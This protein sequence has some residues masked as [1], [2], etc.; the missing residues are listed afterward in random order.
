MPSLAES[1]LRRSQRTPRSM[2]APLFLINLDDATERRE[3]MLAQLH[4]RG[5]VARR[6]GIDCRNLTRRQLAA[7]VARR[8][9]TISFDFESLSGAEI[10]CWMSH[11]AAWAAFLSG[12]SGD[13]CAVIE[14]DV[15]LGPDFV[16]TIAALATQPRFDVVYLGTSSRNVSA[17]RRTSIDGV[18]VHEPLGPVYNTWAYVIRREY[19]ARLFAVRPLRVRVPIDHVL[20]GRSAASA[21]RVGVVQPAVV[22]EE[23][24][25][26]RVSQIEP[27]T[28]RID[29]W[30]LVE[31]AR[32]A[33]LDSRMSAWYY[34]LFRAF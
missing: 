34:A 16:P 6:I 29:R 15:V 25:L 22:R 31:G 2:D 27:Y 12:G 9:P 10:G 14:D 28:W 8:F 4:A 21:H 7:R 11:L 20:G 1:P 32:R 18:W 24:R 19:L 23:P 3:H 13:A 33:F 26:G 30:R 5:V 17:R